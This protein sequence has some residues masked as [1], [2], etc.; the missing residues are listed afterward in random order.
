M[1]KQVQQT[2]Q[3]SGATTLRKQI[4][5]GKDINLALLLYH[6]NEEPQPRTIFSKVLTVELSAP[7]DTRLE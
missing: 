3:N 2:N 6:K 1:E 7:K 4:L 5:E